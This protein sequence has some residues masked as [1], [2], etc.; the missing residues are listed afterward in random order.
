MIP[1]YQII[2]F[3]DGATALDFAPLSLDG[4]PEEWQNRVDQLVE[5]GYNFVVVAHP[6]AGYADISVRDE[7]NNVIAESIVAR[8]NGPD[9]EPFF[10]LITQAL[11]NVNEAKAAGRCE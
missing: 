7:Y 10:Q 3:P 1:F 9:Y 5:D 8:S 4:Q 11:D 2:T 6:T